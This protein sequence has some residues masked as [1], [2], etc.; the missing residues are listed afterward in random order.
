MLKKI[1]MIIIVALIFV[2]DI[3]FLM[4]KRVVLKTPILLEEIPIVYD[5][6]TLEELSEKLNK[7]LNSDVSGKGYLIASY[8]LEMGVDP[9]VA[10]A[11]LLHE[12]G[13]KWDCSY[14]VKSCNNVGGQ[15]GYGCG[16]YSYFPSLDDGIIAFIDNLS[17]NYVS[18][19]LNTP[20]EINTK[21]ASDT[22]WSY[23]VNSYI[24]IIKAQ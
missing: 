4:H 11:I 19:G 2:F 10:T 20:E 24:E 7:S 12:T 6:M 9:Y 14:L 17:Y 16:A 23:K 3:Y 15:K 1:T 13:C 5:N 18:Y 22:S 21:Y 8:S